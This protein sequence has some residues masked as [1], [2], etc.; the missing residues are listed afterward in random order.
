[1]VVVSINYRVGVF[2]FLAHPALTAEAGS[3]GN[4]GLMD[5]VAALKWV[6]RTIARFGGDPDRV[7]IAGQSAGAASVHA[8]LAAP[9]ARG[10]FRG[11]IAQSG[12]GMG[13]AVPPLAAAEAQGMR[14]AAAAG[15][16][17]IAA[18]RRMPADAVA[19]AS[20]APEVG[21]PG[22]RFVPIAEPEFLPDPAAERGDVPVLTGLTADESSSSPD[23]QRADAGGLATLLTKR[24]GASAP[25]FAAYYTTPGDT[26]GAARALLRDQATAAMLLWPDGRAAGAAPVFGYR[27]D[28]PQDDATGRRFGSF[29]TSEVPYVFGTVATAIAQPR[30]VDRTLETLMGRYW[31]NFVQR[32]DPNGPGLPAWPTVSGDRIMMF[33]DRSRAAAPM[34]RTLLDRYRTFARGG[35]TLSLF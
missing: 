35:G 22:L 32:G 27:F 31:I 20:H 11:A 28:H 10:L 24:F 5:Q 14:V 30:A 7:T 8:L 12:S 6:R 25:A 4:Y 16:A 13:I 2:G 21:P 18:L 23:W 33:A 29:H 9:S 17:D 26:T 15:A 3:S 1:M 19:R 34:D